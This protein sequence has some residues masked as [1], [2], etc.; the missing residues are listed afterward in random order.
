MS[1]ITTYLQNPS[2]AAF[3]GAA[4]AF[5]LVTLNDYRRRRRKKRVLTYLIQDQADSAKSKHESVRGMI[6]MMENNV[7]C[8]SP[9]MPFETAQVR[10]IQHEV[11]DLLDANQN[12]GLNALIYWMQ[13]IDELLSRV[14]R[15]SEIL[16]EL[17]R[18]NG[19]N[20]ERQFLGDWI[21]TDLKDAERNMELISRLFDYYVSGKPHLI[22]E[23]QHE[24][25]LPE[26]TGS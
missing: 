20:D 14:Q 3:V 16:E 21:L 18:R 2:V 19:P 25:Q 6:D 11:L 26:R 24:R 15:R 10:L 4:A 9:I 13:A 5:F 23:F 22:L 1:E 7:F 17:Y 12:Q 8:A